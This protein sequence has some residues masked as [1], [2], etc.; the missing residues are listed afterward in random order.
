ML[1]WDASLGQIV[2]TSVKEIRSY[3][4]NRILHC[5]PEKYVKGRSRSVL[6]ELIQGYGGMN[7]W[8]KYYVN[9]L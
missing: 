1:W 4:A 5:Y 2:C 3:R 8:V 6:F 7:D 9:I